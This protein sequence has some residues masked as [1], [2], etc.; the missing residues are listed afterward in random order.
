MC[1]ERRREDSNLAPN[2]VP[3]ATKEAEIT[4]YVRE[5]T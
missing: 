5:R 1:F 3:L 4:D 2:L